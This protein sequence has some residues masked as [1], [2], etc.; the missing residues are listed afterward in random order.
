MCNHDGKTHITPTSLKGKCSAYRG[1]KRIKYSDYPVD[2]DERPE[3]AEGGASHKHAGLVW[4]CPGGLSWP[5]SGVLEAHTYAAIGLSQAA[6][7]KV[8]REFKKRARGT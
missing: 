6:V 7:A 2:V 8:K 1:G 5:R 4:A 3:Y